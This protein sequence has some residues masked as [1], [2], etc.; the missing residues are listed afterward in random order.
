[1]ERPNGGSPDGSGDSGSAG[2]GG[3]FLVLLGFAAF[4]GAM[5]V[6]GRR[7][8][9]RA[10]VGGTYSAA[11]QADTDT[12][13]NVPLPPM[14]SPSYTSGAPSAQPMATPASGRPDDG[15]EEL[16]MAEDDVDEEESWL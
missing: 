16:D 8:L 7:A 3:G 10:R 1:M 12:H 11:R 2:G 9:G 6:V 15:R 14:A 4:A 5:L 13:A